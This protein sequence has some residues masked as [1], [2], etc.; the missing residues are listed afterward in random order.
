MHCIINHSGLT[1]RFI[2][3]LLYDCSEAGKLSEYLEPAADFIDEAVSAGGKVLV[4]CI[5][6]KCQ[7]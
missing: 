5:A 1:H 3:R 4:H 7:G 6:G 2:D